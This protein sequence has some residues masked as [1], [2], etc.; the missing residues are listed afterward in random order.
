MWPVVRLPWNGLFTWN[1]TVAHQLLVSAGRWSSS[2]WSFVCDRAP[3]D[4]TIAAK[5]NGNYEYKNNKVELAMF[6]NC[7]GCRGRGWMVKPVV[8]SPFVVVQPKS[9]ALSSCCAHG[10]SVR[11]SDQRLGLLGEEA[12]AGVHQ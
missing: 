9:C 7:V 2:V 6:M 3:F 11:I 10:E 4:K 12:H 8:L 1:G 5:A